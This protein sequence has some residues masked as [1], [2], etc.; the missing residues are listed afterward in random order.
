MKMNRAGLTFL[1]SVI[2]T[3]Y[4]SLC[5]ETIDA[6]AGE[7][8]TRS[9]RS[10]FIEESHPVGQSLSNI[11]L[12][13]SGFEHDLSENR[14]DSDPIQ[15]V[16]VADLDGDGFDEFYI[17]TVSSGSGSYGNIVGFASNNDK[18]LSMIYFPEI[19]EGDERFDGYMGH[20]VFDF[21]DNTLIRAFPVYLSTDKN[22]S[23]HGG[24]RKVTYGLFKGE[25]SWQLRIIDSEETD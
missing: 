3:C 22:V 17:V 13:S 12:R 15:A 11:Q 7:Y 4:F 10:L 23:S 25:A 20:D 24:T 6:Y 1:L 16:H 21:S 2:M 14:I 18:S 5:L 9:G 19:Q 8:V